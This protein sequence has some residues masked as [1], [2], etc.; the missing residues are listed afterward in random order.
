MSHELLNQ[1][2]TYLKAGISSN[3]GI[4]VG[5]N[6]PLPICCAANWIIKRDD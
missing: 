3:S 1:P 6:A 4:D 5:E 2:Q